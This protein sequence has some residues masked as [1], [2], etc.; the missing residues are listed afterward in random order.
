MQDKMIYNLLF[1]NY[2]LKPMLNGTLYPID[3]SVDILASFVD[4]YL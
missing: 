1:T 3:I 2:V 4:W